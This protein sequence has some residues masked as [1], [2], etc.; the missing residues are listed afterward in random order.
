MQRHGGRGS[1][2]W[3]SSGPPIGSALGGSEPEQAEEEASKTLGE[4]WTEWKKQTRATL[5][6]I[7]R[8]LSLVWSTHKGYTLAM[9]FLT[10]VF[11]LIPAA[12]AWVS[13][14]LVNAVLAAIKVG[15]RGDTTMVVVELVVLQFALL[16]GSSLLQ[17][18]SN[19]NQQALQ[20]LTARRV[21][22]MLMRHA[23]RLDLSFF[24]NPASTT[25]CSRRRREAGY[26]P[27]QMVSQMFGLV[28]S[29]ITFF[30]MI[31]LIASL[32]WIVAVA[33]LIAPIPSFIAS[34]RYG[35]QGY[36]ISR[37]QSPDRRRMTYFLDLLT[38]DTYNKEIKLF[39]LGDFFIDKWEE[40]SDRFFK[41]N[42]SLVKRRYLDGLRVG[43]PFHGGHERHLPVRGPGSHRGPA[44]P[45]RPH[46]LHAGG[47]LG[48]EQPQ[49]P[50]GRPLRY[51]REQ[52]LSYQ[53][54]RA[55]STTRRS[56]KTRPT[57]ANWNCL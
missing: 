27:T 47:R 11:G 30:S 21:Q 57:H 3:W 33:S 17:T 32:G 22:L 44:H 41:E 38:R 19:I 56:Y 1:R 43:Q 12:T 50:A 9:A 18:I 37:R 34:S 49:Q 6:G 25:R 26:R 13:K 42:R 16:A 5:A 54:V 4:R 51:V 29:A 20:E 52:P 55:S 46:L 2:N 7:P 31:A 39:G 36:M 23:N 8:A 14:L 48:A 35:W 53:P 28:R 10:V 15:G 24:E 40:I 45:G